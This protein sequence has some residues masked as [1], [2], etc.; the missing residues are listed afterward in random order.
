MILVDSSIWVD[1]LR[2]GEPTLVRLLESQTVLGHP[3]IVG[4]LA[5]GHLRRP[6][7]IISLLT[8]L[9][10]ALMATPSEVLH[11]IE[12]ADLSGRGIGYMDAQLVAATLMTPEAKL[13]TRDRRLA[14]VAADLD[15]A[16]EPTDQ[17]GRDSTGGRSHTSNTFM[18]SSP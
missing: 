15:R 18:T 3:W 8:A 7:E 13:W 6:S 2:V 1:H 17:A 12:R 9:P 11:L 10:Q 16:F 5:L 14:A 4:E